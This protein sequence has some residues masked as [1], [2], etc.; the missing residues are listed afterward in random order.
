MAIWWRQMAIWTGWPF[1]KKLRVWRE[2][3]AKVK[4]AIWAADRPFCQLP[5]SPIDK[6]PFLTDFHSHQSQ[7]LPILYHH[8]YSSCYHF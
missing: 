8:P 7:S 2:N 1:G 5:I 3:F 4:M 6:P